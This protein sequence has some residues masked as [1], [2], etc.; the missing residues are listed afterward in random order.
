LAL[1]TI[2]WSVLGKLVLVILV[3]NFRT[4]EKEPQHRVARH[5]GILD[6]PFRREMGVL[7]GPAIVSGKL[8]SV[9]AVGLICYGLYQIVKEPYRELR[10]S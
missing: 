2:A 3:L 8:L 9:T 1:W 6:P 7:L 5:Y 10:R 4:P